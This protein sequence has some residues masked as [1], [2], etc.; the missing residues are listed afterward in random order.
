M[1][2]EHKLAVFQVNRNQLQ[3]G[4]NAMRPDTADILGCLRMKAKSFLSLAGGILL[5]LG[6]F[7][8][9][10]VVVQAEETSPKGPDE[11]GEGYS[12]FH[13]TMADMTWP[14]VERAAKDGA[15]VLLPTGV[16]EEHGPHLRLGTDTYMAY[17]RC[18]LIRRELEK[19]G[20][21][22]IIAPPF[23]WGVNH[24]TGAFPGS[25]SSRPETVKAVIYDILSS[26]KRWGF[27]SVFV[28]NNHGDF[29]HNKAIIEGVKEAWAGTGIRARYISPINMGGCIGIYNASA[30]GGPG[31]GFTGN[32]AWMLFLPP[33]FPGPAPQY[34][35]IHAGNPET[36]ATAF[37]FPQLVDF[38]MAKKLAPSN[39]T[40]D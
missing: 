4:G 37:Y 6:L 36:S 13:G 10:I 29:Y 5:I 24:A 26:L 2:L 7:L 23:Y 16:I 15:I 30:S 32:E 11:T 31:Y 27:E 19:R 40:P 28:V 1:L 18:K 33:I 25:F 3:K 8:G 39:T 21:K 12:I 34:C 20:I 38:E 22:T 17:L 9:S 35:D 14:E